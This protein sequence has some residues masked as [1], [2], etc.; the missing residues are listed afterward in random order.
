MLTVDDGIISS[1]SRTGGEKGFQLYS[2][3]FWSE[4][5]GQRLKEDLEYEFV[6]NK[7]KDIYWDDIAMFCHPNN[8]KLGIRKINNNDLIE[9]DSLEELAAVDNSYSSYL[10]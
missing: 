8:Y 4:E 1:C 10:K 6:H 2:V 9:I 7:N 5:D 3:S